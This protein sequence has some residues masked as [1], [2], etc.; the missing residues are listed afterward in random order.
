[1]SNPPPISTWGHVWR[2]ALVVLLSG[3]TWWSLAPWQWQHRPAWF[4]SDLALG[5][6]ALGVAQYRRRW[7]V[8]VA[9]VVTLASAFSATASGPATLVLFSL[10]TRRRWREILPVAVL[11]YVCSVVQVA[12]DPTA[13]DGMALTLSF[14]AAVLAVMVGWGMY[15][16]SRRELLG[17]LRERAHRAETEQAARVAAARTAERT[18]IAREMHDVLAHR[19]SMVA[20]HAGALSFRDDLTPEQVK[21]T[22]SV[23]Q[24]SSHRALAELRQVL[25]VLRD[26]P[27]DAAPEPPQP[28]ATQVADLVREAASSGMN[29]E[30][31]GLEILPLVPDTIG[32][33]AYRVVQEGLTNAR[34]HAPDTL[35]TISTSGAPESG[36]QLEISNRL[37]LGRTLGAPESG[38][39]LVG[40]AERA[41]L[42]GGRLTRIRDDRSFTLRVWLPWPA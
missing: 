19:I 25:G 4:W 11:S 17:T 10:A 35:V 18:R 27:G 1:M 39:G 12:Q 14:L 26:D 5:I 42:A 41:E 31:S 36:L 7:P 2:T 15:V 28:S 32:R 6:A 3:M 30:S 40:L 34:K 22:A 24:E 8:V 20:M 38:L 23:I 16:G 13:D 29:I 21:E 9:V 37:P 33:T